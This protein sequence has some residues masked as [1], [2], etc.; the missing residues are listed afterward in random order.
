MMPSTAFTDPVS[1]EVD[2]KCQRCQN[3]MTEEE[4]M[5][6]GDEVSRR[7]VSVSHCLN[8]GRMEYRAMVD[9]NAIQEEDGALR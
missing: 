8:C 1:E 4:I 2:M 6:S 3:L 5:L 9:T 7:P